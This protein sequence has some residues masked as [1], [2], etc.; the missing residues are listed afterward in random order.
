MTTRF[1]EAEAE[2]I[3]AVRGTMDR[4]PWLRLAALAAVERQ[5]PPAAPPARKAKPATCPHRLP[6]GAWCKTCQ[7]SKP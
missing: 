4:S 2:A 6:A 5:Q 3:D 7:Q 1:S